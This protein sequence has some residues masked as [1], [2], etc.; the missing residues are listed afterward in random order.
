[1]VTR[2]FPLRAWRWHRLGAAGGVRGR[3]GLSSG[4]PWRRRSSSFARRRR[5]P[6][7]TA[8]TDA[9]PEPAQADPVGA[10]LVANAEFWRDFNDP[11]LT[12]LVEDSLSANHDLRIALANYDRANAL[13]RG[14]KFDTSRR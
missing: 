11:L 4:R 13:L 6:R 12:R 5:L 9:A 7:P 1:M 3:A 8:P 14:A 2:P 10:P